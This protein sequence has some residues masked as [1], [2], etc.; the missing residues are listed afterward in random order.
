[1]RKAR[2][3]P[4]VMKITINIVGTPAVILK[5]RSDEQYGRD[6]I[7]FASGKILYLYFGGQ[8]DVQLNNVVLW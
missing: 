2:T 7:S 1:M 3:S 6:L 4:K 5:P 8:M